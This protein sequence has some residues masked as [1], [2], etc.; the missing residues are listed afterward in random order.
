[1]NP[2][3]RKL[4][5]AV[6]GAIVNQVVAPIQVLVMGNNESLV[7]DGVPAGAKVVLHPFDLVGPS[8]QVVPRCG[9]QDIEVEVLAQLMHGLDGTRHGKHRAEETRNLIINALAVAVVGIL[10]FN[11]FGHLIESTLE[12]DQHI[13]HVDVNYFLAHLF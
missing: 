6:L 12:V 11:L 7:E 4:L 1:M 3:A 13:V 5:G 10:C 2:L 8:T 9:A